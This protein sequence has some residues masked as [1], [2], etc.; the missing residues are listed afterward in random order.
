VH[1]RR[2]TTIQLQSNDR[3][4]IEFDG[5]PFEFVSQLAVRESWR[6]EIHRPIYHLHK[7][8]ANRLGSVF[9][10]LIL[11]AVLGP[12]ANLEQEF[13]KV[14]HLRETVV[15]DPFMGSGTTVGEAYKLGCTSLGQDI[16]PVAA[17]G[18]RISFGPMERQV[19]NEAMAGLASSVGKRIGGLYTSRDREGGPA[20]TLYHFWV[21]QA[22][23]PQCDSE[24][25]L[26]SSR[27]FASNACPRKH[28][29][30]ELTC[31]DCG[32]VFRETLASSMVI[33]PACGIGFDPRTGSVR[34][35]NYTCRVC[36]GISKIRESVA[37]SSRPPRY[38]PFAKLV[39][40]QTGAKEYLTTDA[41]DEDLLTRSSNELR[42]EEANGLLLPTTRLRDGYNTRQ[43][44]A[45][46]F[47]TWRDFFNDRQLLALGLL[48]KAV[49]EI[50]DVAA[51]DLLLNLFSGVLEFNNRFTSYKGEGTGAV[52][53]MFSHH[54]LRPERTPIEANVWGTEK[55]SGSFSGLY[56]SRVLRAISYRQRPTE[57]SLRSD[58][59]KPVSS[60]PFTGIVA[61]SFLPAVVCGKR[62]VYLSVGDSATTGLSSASVDLVVTDPPFF[63]NVH[64]SELA[65]FFYSWDILTPRGFIDGSSTT[66]S[67]AEVQ[68]VDYH[69]F[70]SK[71]SGVFTECAR[72]LRPSGLLVFTFHQSRGE[73]WRGVANAL[74]RAGF[75]PVNAHPV[76]SELRVAIPKVATRQPIHFDIAV[77]CRL[78][79]SSMQSE[80]TTITAALDSAARKVK[81]LQNAGFIVS[82]NDSG[83][84]RAGQLLTCLQDPASHEE[85]LD[86]LTLAE[87]LPA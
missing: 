79:T 53:H 45:Y 43:A 70:E 36:G 85:V 13:Y 63:D 75:V 56:R 4:L 55:S 69:R 8:W 14:H 34:G 73:S 17:E 19:L 66:R 42:I 26:F 18:A 3:R 54:I 39:L 83:I 37:T 86:R 80:P 87:G 40:T 32:D 82:E 21:M 46:G 78:R 11:A 74:L 35:E 76:W 27:V 2:V 49:S 25:D 23:C 71:L 5:F 58:G 51:R 6:K 65:D 72:V 29:E 30:V 24:T 16:N 22:T 7:W 77:C 61:D 84:V 33:C 57:V 62:S 67:V 41:F 31:P 64:Y 38:R 1:R 9:R 12:H 50:E 28:P 81:R 52:R 15:F 48:R 44:M 59:R 68:D 10:G 20:T 60:P 47:R